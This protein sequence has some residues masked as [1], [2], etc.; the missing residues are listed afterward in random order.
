MKP[1]QISAVLF[2]GFELLD[3]FGPLEMFGLLGGR[4]RLRLLAEDVGPV[5][6]SAGIQAFA[7]Y[8]IEEGADILLVPG[9]IGTRQLVESPGFLERL[10][11]VAGASE[12]VAS[13]CT[14]SALLARAGLLDGKRA[15]SNKLAFEWVVSQ[16]P[17][18]NWQRRAR[19]VVDGSVWT[20]SGI[21]AGMDMSL[22]VIADRFD[23]ATASEIARRAEYLWNES[24]EEDPFA[25]E[26]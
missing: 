26:K 24:S 19:W 21:A 5:M 13:V 18:V 25:V 2:P 3:V 16:G 22:A 6:S 10:R 7:D 17:K 4:A 9:G 11:K 23:H 1:L 14:G 20:S 12:I 8:R 15:T